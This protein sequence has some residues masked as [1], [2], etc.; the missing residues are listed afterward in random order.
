MSNKIKTKE[1]ISLLLSIG[2]IVPI[3]GTFHDLIGIKLVWPAF[4]S[5][6]LFFAS[7]CKLKD[8]I[9][10]AVSHLIG[11]GWGIIFFTILNLP[12]LQLYDNRSVLFCTLCFLG[13][14]AVIVS[15][16][17]INV[18]SHLPSIF[19]GWAITVGTL[20]GVP[21]KDWGILPVDTF[22]SIMVGIFIIGVG[23]SQ[24]QELLL[25]MSQ[26]TFNK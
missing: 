12:Q 16:M 3:W 5:S 21:I 22:L 1:T 24:L 25:R 9:N 6:A 11:I 13:V 8:S 14:L 19:S 20:D 10:I 2:L 15:N 26:K 18:V 4:A 23:I 17:G 7:N